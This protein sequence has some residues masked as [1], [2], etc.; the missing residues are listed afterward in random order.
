[1]G[2]AYTE[3]LFHSK[4]VARFALYSFVSVYLFGLVS[5]RGK[6]SMMVLEGRDQKN[7]YQDFYQQPLPWENITVDR[8]HPSD[9]K[10]ENSVSVRENSYDLAIVGAGDMLDL[11]L[12]SMPKA[13][14]IAML[15]LGS[16]AKN[17]YKYSQSGS[18]FDSHCLK[19]ILQKKQVPINVY[20]AG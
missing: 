9:E 5:E 20:L 15:I 8:F 2:Q 17:F 11:S 1:M 3:Y 16:E 10:K 4:D 18:Y 19:K 12:G 6:A 14:C 13:Q 7:L